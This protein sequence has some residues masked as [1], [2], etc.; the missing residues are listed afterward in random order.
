MKIENEGRALMKKIDDTERI[1][2]NK[3]CSC[4]KDDSMLLWFLDG[5][6]HCAAWTD[7]EE[8]PEEAVIIAADFCYLLGEVKHPDEI[9]QILLENARYKVIMTGGPQWVAFMKEY[10]A[11]RTYSYKRYAIKHEPNAFNKDKLKQLIE[12]IDS[13]FEI[14]K[15]NEDTYYEVLD[16]DWAADGCCFFR[17]YDDFEANGLGYI[18]CKEGQLVCIASSYTA[19]KNSISITIGTL[20]EHRRKGLAAACAA[21]LI[22]DCLERGIYPEWEAANLESVALAESLG[23]HFDKAFD[24]Y[25]L[26]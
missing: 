6:Q 8:I 14:K 19:Y 3:L 1:N 21:S 9:V 4:R 22:L 10:L 20:E 24:V 2:L 13:V 5:N 25:S 16:I 17:S 23:Y 12:K 7:G 11:D 18:V 15:I 26:I